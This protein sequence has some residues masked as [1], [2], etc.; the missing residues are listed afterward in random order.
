VHYNVL[1]VGDFLTGSECNIAQAPG[2]LTSLELT[3]R[4]PTVRL[5]NGSRETSACF[6]NALDLD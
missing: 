2:E 1:C 5:A 3:G 6:R 4:L